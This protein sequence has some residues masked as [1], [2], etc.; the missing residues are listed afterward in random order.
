MAKNPERPKKLNRAA[1]TRNAEKIAG[2]IAATR[3]RKL[4]K[5]QFSGSPVRRMAASADAGA[6]M[7]SWKNM[8]ESARRAGVDIEGAIA[9]NGSPEALRRDIRRQTREGLG[10]PKSNAPAPGTG[11]DKRTFPQE[12]RA[13]AS[14]EGQAG[15]GGR[16][17]WDSHQKTSRSEAARKAWATRRRNAGKA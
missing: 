9:R 7:Q 3:D 4:N 17:R 13:G 10:A 14:V 2:Q 15:I 12:G 6:Y 16:A 1:T 8:G 5:G 11:K